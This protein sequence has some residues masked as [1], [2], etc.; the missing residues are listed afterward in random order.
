MVLLTQSA[1]HDPAIV[2]KIKRQLTAGG[3]VT[4]TSGLLRALQGK[5]I[6]DIVELECTDRRVAIREFL[7]GYGAGNG[8]SLNDRADNPAI[9]FP[10]IRFFTNDSWTLIRGVVKAKGFP[11][12]LMNRY[13]R[14]VLYVLNIPDNPGDLYNLPQPVTK[15]IKSY[16]QGNFPVRID[17]SDR[18]SLF[19]YDNKTFIVQSFRDEETT[20]NV[21]IA[22]AGVKLRNLVSDQRLTTLPAVVTARQA[23]EPRSEVAV[24]LQAHS[25]QVYAIE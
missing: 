24:L 17:A 1:A 19:T 3:N 15:V 8:S 9:L 10:E 18:V 5:G 25:Y 14:G 7:N 12:L 23:A 22:G 11:I 4:I 2:G 13:S 20:V 21:S 6:E 16:L